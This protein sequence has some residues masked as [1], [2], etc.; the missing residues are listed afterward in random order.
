MEPFSIDNHHLVAAYQDLLEGGKPQLMF[1]VK[2]YK[3]K[4]EIENDFYA[5]VYECRKGTQEYFE[6]MYTGGNASKSDGTIV[7]HANGCMYGPYIMLNGGVYKVFFVAHPAG[8]CLCRITANKGVKILHEELVES[9]DTI[10]FEI[11]EE[12]QDVEFFVQ[13]VG[14]EQISITSVVIRKEEGK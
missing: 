5:Y 8:K 10:R 4:K 13:N 7:L 6:E 12:E 2:S 9:L 11:E 1:Y 3:S 14:T